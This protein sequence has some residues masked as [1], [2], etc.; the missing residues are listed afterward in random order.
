MLPV[1]PNSSTTVAT[2]TN[3]YFS[4]SSSSSNSDFFLKDGR[5]VRVGDCALFKPPHDSLP[6]IGLIQKVIAGKEDSLSLWV[7]WLYRPSD[8]K[9]GKGSLLDIAPNEG[10]PRLYAEEC[11][12]LR[13][14]VYGG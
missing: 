13:T 5:K 1:P 11:M 10:Y 8:I 14:S 6:F 3:F 7:N 2:A 12:I 9:L 4:S